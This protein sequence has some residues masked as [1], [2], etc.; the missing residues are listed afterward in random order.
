MAV[1]YTVLKKPPSYV[2]TGAHIK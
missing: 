2:V 1:L